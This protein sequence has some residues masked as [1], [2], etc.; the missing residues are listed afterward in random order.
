MSKKLYILIIAPD[1]QMSLVKSGS[2]LSL[3][4]VNVKS[5]LEA[6]FTEPLKKFIEAEDGLKEVGYNVSR[7]KY[8]GSMSKDDID[9]LVRESKPI[10]TISYSAIL[11]VSNDEKLKI[12]K[13]K[14]YQF[15]KTYEEKAGKRELSTELNNNLDAD[16]KSFFNTFQYLTDKTGNPLDKCINSTPSPT[17]SASTITFRFFRPIFPLPLFIRPGLFG[18][19]VVYSSNLPV[20]ASPFVSP[21][22]SRETSPVTP[23]FSNVRNVDAPRVPRSPSPKV[24]RTRSPSPVVPRMRVGGYYEK[25]MKYKLKYLKLKEELNL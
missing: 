14:K 10:G 20:V 22:I 16:G 19:T 24:P 11:K 21:V 2:T 5:H 15:Y 7:I 23:R 4:F 1:S 6:D 25:Y 3:P 17:S 8:C 12:E 18:P 9:K 13:N